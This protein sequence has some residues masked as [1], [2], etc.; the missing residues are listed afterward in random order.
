MKQLL[1]SR[2]WVGIGADERRRLSA[3]FLIG[4]SGP[5]EVIN[6]ELIS[7]GTTDKDL[8]ALSIARMIEYLGPDLSWYQ[9]DLFSFL[10]TLTLRK[11]N[12]DTIQSEPSD[13]EVQP[14]EAKPRP[15]GRPKKE[16]GQV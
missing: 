6:N 13:Q 10:L 4:R 15:R 3:Q 5:T 11:L 1:T 14:S 16:E 2:D 9:E 12:G 7:D 8:Q